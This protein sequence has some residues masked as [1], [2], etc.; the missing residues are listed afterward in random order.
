MKN[1]KHIVNFLPGLL[2]LAASFLPLQVF[3]HANTTDFFTC[4]IDNDAWY[5]GG[6][7]HIPVSKDLN[8]KES[9]DEAAFAGQLQCDIEQSELLYNNLT[10]SSYGKVLSTDIAIHLYASYPKD[11]DDRYNYIQSTRMPAACFVHYLYYKRLEELASVNQTVGSCRHNSDVVILAGGDGSGKTFAVRHL[12]LP[13]LEK[14]CV[15]KDCTLSGDFE[16]YRDL[17]KN[18]LESNFHVTIVYVFRPIELALIGNINRAQDIGRIRSLVEIASAHCQAQ[19]NVLELIKYFGDKIDVIAIDN[20]LS[21]DEVSLVT[22]PIAFI[23]RPEVLY[24]STNAVIERALAAYN[25]LNKDEIP[26]TIKNLLESKLDSTVSSEAEKAHWSKSNYIQY[27]IS[28]IGDKIW[29]NTSF[30]LYS[31][32]S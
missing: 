4:I 20:S 32:R 16:Y 18:T 6:M 12:G 7:L 1:Y 15:I 19:Q 8:D 13:I 3:A 30:I 5:Y 22:D 26:D 10:D 28:L 29:I 11:V 17:V 24:E 14:A 23:Q 31:I 25:S 27:I 9:M 2:F 21:F